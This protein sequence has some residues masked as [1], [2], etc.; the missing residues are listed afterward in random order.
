MVGIYPFFLS[1]FFFFD[2]AMKTRK[3]K[4]PSVKDEEEKPHG[5]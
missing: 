5:Q 4:T 2:N 1:I 3:N